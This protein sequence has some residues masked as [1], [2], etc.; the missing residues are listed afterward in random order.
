[1]WDLQVETYNQEFICLS[2]Q[3][4]EKETV[5]ACT[6]RGELNKDVDEAIQAVER[7]TW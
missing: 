6:Y 4:L 2:L 1:M 3:L 7:G 5:E